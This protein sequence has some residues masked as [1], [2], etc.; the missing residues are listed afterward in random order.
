MNASF[1][2]IVVVF[3]SLSSLQVKACQPGSPN[4]GRADALFIGYVTGE[5]WPDMEAEYLGGKSASDVGNARG[6]PLLVARVVQTELLKGNAPGVVE[7]TSL[8]ALP[9]RAGERVIVEYSNGSYYVWPAELFAGGEKSI[10]EA[11]RRR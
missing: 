8:C 3:L 5:R 4:V 6:Y 1:S 9:L 11:L 2:V 10:R 7:A